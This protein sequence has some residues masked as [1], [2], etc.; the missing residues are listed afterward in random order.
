MPKISIITVN[1]N[2]AEGLEQ[3]I[4]SVISQDLQ[5]FEYLVV[6]GKSTDGSLEV[7]ERQASFIDTWIS[8][9]DTGV[10]QAMNKGIRMATGEYLLFL[11]SGDV[12]YDSQ[13]LRAVQEK[14]DGGKD[15]YYGNLIFT[16]QGKEMLR[17]Y[18][19]DLRFSY[20]LERSLPHPGSFIK[21][22][23]FERIFYYSEVFKIVSDW[24]FFI[25]AIC[26]EGMSYEHLNMLISR[27]DL[28]GMSNDPKNKAQIEE[29]RRLVIQKHFPAMYEDAM[30]LLKQQK[31][32]NRKDVQMQLKHSKTGRRISMKIAKLLLKLFPEKSKGI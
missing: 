3:T 22:D 25:C 23:L 12:L 4:A 29:E 17:E 16:S 5:D 7:I 28:E 1:Y 8:E 10:Y 24:E 9:A 30:A 26:K 20:F 18:P 27:F 31:L 14:I 21:K 19:E 6:D 15:L 2:N 11:N 13:V 32:L